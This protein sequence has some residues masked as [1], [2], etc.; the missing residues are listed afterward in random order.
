MMF[1]YLEMIKLNGFGLD[2]AFSVLEEGFI[3]KLKGAIL[4]EGIT[5]GVLSIV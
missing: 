1:N 5:S 3:S 2:P 4:V